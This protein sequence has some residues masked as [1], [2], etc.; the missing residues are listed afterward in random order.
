[1]YIDS[2]IGYSFMT[3]G[4][5]IMDHLFRR[6]DSIKERSLMPPKGILQKQQS[7]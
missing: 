6:F 2:E 5:G 1:M 3:T 7:S 4:K